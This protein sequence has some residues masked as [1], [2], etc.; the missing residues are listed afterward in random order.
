MNRTVLPLAIAVIC[1]LVAVFYLIPGPTHPFVT[2]DPTG[3]HIKHTLL[4]FGLA[5]LS[6]IWAR[7]AANARG[8]AVDRPTR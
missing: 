8:R 2:D 1:V 5:V 6:V 3:P 7:F 4:F